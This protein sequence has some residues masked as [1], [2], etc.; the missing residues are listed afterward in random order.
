[1]LFWLVLFFVLFAVVSV[2]GTVRRM[3]G[4][5][6]SQRRQ[7]EQEQRNDDTMARQFVNRKID[8]NK[9]ED[10]EFEEIKG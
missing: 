7:Q 2:I 5:R 6:P 8:K 9:A 10:V 3:L 1:M 4:M